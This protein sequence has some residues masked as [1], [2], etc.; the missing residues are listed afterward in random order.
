MSPSS[1]VGLN[2]NH[3]KYYLELN[4][5]DTAMF[6]GN[7]YFFS[8]SFPITYAGASLNLSTFGSYLGVS[9]K[10][11]KIRIFQ[12]N[13]DGN[14]EEVENMSNIDNKMF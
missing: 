11:N 14:W 13:L 12:E 8:S 5:I 3:H 2:Y 9:M 4:N 7:Y 10:N 6:G 1:L